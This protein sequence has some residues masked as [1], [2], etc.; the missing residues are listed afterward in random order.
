MKYKYIAKTSNGIIIKGSA[1]SDSIEE[2]ALGLRA[3]EIFLIKGRSIKKISEISTRPNLKIISMF[4]KQFSICLK[5]GIPI[6]DI[7]NLLYE[8]MLHKAIKNSLISIRENVQK[9]NSLYASMKNTRNIYPEF[10]INMIYLGEE[11]GKLDTILEELSRYYEKEHKLTKKFVN[12]MIYPCT[13]FLTLTIVSL[14]LFIKVIPIFI[15]NLNSLNADI[16]LITRIVLGTSNFLGQNFLWILII[17]LIVAFIFMEYFKTENGKLAFDKFKFRCPILGPVYKHLIYT[18]FT[19]GLNILLCSGVG[20]LRAFEIIYDVIGNRY[21]KLKLK[22]VFN[23]IKKG[24]D[25]A[26]CLNAMNLFPQFFVAMVRIGEETGN[27]DEMFLTAADIFYEEAEEKV[28]KGTA[29]LEPI[30]IIFL[31][32]MIGTIILAVMLPMLSVMDSAGKI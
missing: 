19:R 23:D 4:C 25:L 28:E 7:L 27:L 18:R 2:L 3:Q 1:E 31:G 22:T 6:C 20:L 10:L 26:D 30:L 21:F 8:Q 24:R 12:S 15:K 17:N 16:P 9:G 5:S 11:S 13:V 14:F 32:I 29:L